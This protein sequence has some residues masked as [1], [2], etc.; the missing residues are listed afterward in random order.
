MPN[1]LLATVDEFEDWLKLATGALEGS[2][3][4]EMLIDMASEA[5]RG[6]TG[7]MVTLVTDDAISLPGSGLR[8]IQLPQ[9]PVV[10]ITS[11]SIGGTLLTITDDWV[12]G[13]SGILYRRPVDS[14]WVVGDGN[15]AVVYSHGYP[16]DDVPADIRGVV[17]AA[18]ARAWANPT[19]LQ[20]EGTATYQASYGKGDA[21]SGAT[22]TLLEDEK[23]T[24]DARFGLAA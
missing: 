5:V 8:S 21:F 24:L 18:A 6:H 9:I 12:H 10:N 4:A 22:I 2:T 3:R 1:P 7:Q 11:V 19:S 23:A 13:G 16:E 20:S 17:L 14:V 15:V